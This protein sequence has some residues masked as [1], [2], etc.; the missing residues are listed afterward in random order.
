MC[1]EDYEAFC[2]H[3][4]EMES[5]SSLRKLDARSSQTKWV[6]QSLHAA[7]QCIPGRRN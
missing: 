1:V 3:F 7:K 5:D 2:T 6:T 4:R